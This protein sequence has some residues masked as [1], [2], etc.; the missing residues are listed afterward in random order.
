MFSRYFKFGL[1][2]RCYYNLNLTNENNKLSYNQI[3]Y[4][5]KLHG[6]FKCCKQKMSSWLREQSMLVLKACTKQLEFI[7]AQRIRRS[8]Q[9]FHL[10]TRIYDEVALNTL[11]RSLRHKFTKNSCNFLVGAVGFSFYNWDQDRIG[12]EEILR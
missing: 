2:K 3:L 10:Y 4:C 12:D 6:K 8:V 11:L 9:I 1:F 5:C 7:A